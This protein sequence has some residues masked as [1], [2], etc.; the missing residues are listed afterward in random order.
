MVWGPSLKPCPFETCTKQEF[1]RTSADFMSVV[2][3]WT[4]FS[5]PI[6][7]RLPRPCSGANGLTRQTTSSSREA[8]RLVGTYSIVNLCHKDHHQWNF[9]PVMDMSGKKAARIRR[10]AV[11]SCRV[12][13]S[14]KVGKGATQ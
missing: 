3:Q 11:Q 1:V 7:P 12:D 14:M 13:L 5:K 2:S 4:F 9:D 10:E 8:R 6:P